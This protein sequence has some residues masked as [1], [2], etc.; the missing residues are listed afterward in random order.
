MASTTDDFVGFPRFGYHNVLL[1][2]VL[3]ASWYK[4][5][6]FDVIV[7]VFLRDIPSIVVV[8]ILC[9]MFSKISCPYLCSRGWW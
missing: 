1:C 5:S 4:F 9:A 8:V 6:P 3:G 7:V 2:V